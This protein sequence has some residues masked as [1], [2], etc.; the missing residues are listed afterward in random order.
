MTDVAQTPSSRGSCTAPSSAESD[1]AFMT[2]ENIPGL[3]S[4]I[5]T[6]SVES[7][8]RYF[9]GVGYI[10]DER[11]VTRISHAI[12]D[13]TALIRPGGTYSLCP[14]IGKQS[15]SGLSLKNGL[16]LP[17]PSCCIDPGARFLA[18]AAGTLGDKLE[19]K[20]RELA[21]LGKIYQSTLL[22]AVGTAT[23]D[24]CGETI[25][26]AIVE[27]SRVSGLRKG[28]RFAPGLDGY[29]LKHQLLLFK[30]VDNKSVGLS[31]NSSEIMM[32][33]KSIS[34]F[35]MVTENRLKIDEAG[36]CRSCR[37]SKCQFRLKE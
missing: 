37:M 26:N 14:I 3:S 17:I 32:P 12:T 18:A 25:C 33:T 15:G 4:I 29:P 9:G 13:A 19:K 21:Q 20:C 36:K 8:A 27:D 31:L 1:G 34:F 6:V 16:E 30:I 11:T 10:P 35:L 7:V 28:Y 22:D 5:S 23:L 2:A 24:L